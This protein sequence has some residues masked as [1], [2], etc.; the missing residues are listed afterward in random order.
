MSPCHVAVLEG[1]GI[2][3]HWLDLVEA[4]LGRHR[5]SQRILMHGTWSMLSTAKAID[6]FFKLQKPP[7]IPEEV[8]FKTENLNIIDDE[9]EF[10]PVH[11]Q[12]AFSQ[13]SWDG[14]F[15]LV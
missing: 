11:G 6:F 12:S 3:R 13:S 9:D 4:T 7:G 5:K 8:Y 2:I 1:P 14:W 15:Y 10:I